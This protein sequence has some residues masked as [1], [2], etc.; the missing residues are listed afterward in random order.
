MEEFD[1]VGLSPDQWKKMWDGD[2]SDCAH[3]EDHCSETPHES[4]GDEITDE[5]EYG[6]K[7]KVAD[8]LYRNIANLTAGKP[9]E[10]VLI[11]LCGD[12]PDLEWLCSKGYSVV[13]L[14]LSET[15][16]K[17]IFDK[18]RAG[19]IP[20]EV[21]S[22]EGFMI[23]SAT[24]GKPL[25]VYVGDFFGDRMNPDLLGTFNCIWDAHGIVSIPV[26]QQ[27]RYAEK[28]FT[29]LKPGGK[30][31]F[32]TVDYD[33]GKLTSGPAPAPVPASKLS[34]FFPNCD[35]N[36]LEEK[37]LPRWE[38]EGVEHWSNQVILISSP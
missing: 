29:F 1:K 36:L 25:K 24:D 14:E 15:A 28:L 19:P 37:A 16:V 6:N 31:L 3:S 38:L 5:D 34:D 4:C 32:S 30:I 23:Y 20:F 9:K 17:A 27:Q 26:G 22:E 13:G 21:S 33:I 11:S 10:T 2:F 35:V 8:I 18:A 7:L 12:S